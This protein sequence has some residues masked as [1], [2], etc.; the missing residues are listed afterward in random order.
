MNCAECQTDPLTPGHYCPCC[1]RKLSLQEQRAAEAN[2]PACA[3][4]LASAIAAEPSHDVTSAAPQNTEVAVQKAEA[5]DMTTEVILPR[6]VVKVD[7]AKIAKAKA[8][9][10][11]TAKAHL[12]KA[13]NPAPVVRR[14][15]VPPPPPPPQR[16][17]RTPML[18][19]AAAVIVGA[20]GAAEG[21]RRLG[22]EWPGHEAREAAPVE[23]TA[24][25]ESVAPV[26]R[27]AT[28]RQAASAPANHT[29]SI[30][31]SRAAA[32]PKVSAP[33]ARRAPVR[34]GN[35]TPQQVAP[36]VART[37]A[38]ETP[39]P[40]PK[41]IAPKAAES[42]RPS[43]PLTGRFF[44]SNDVDEPPHIARRVAPRLPANLPAGA[45]KKI[46]VARVLVSRTG[47]PYH[48]SLLRGS[49]LGRASDEAVIAAVTQWTFSPARKR[50]EAVNCWYN[51]GVPLARAN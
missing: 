40:A 32:K 48:V 34:Q 3:A 9:A 15:I 43:A 29:T 51:I 42:A 24:P 27:R 7:A 16:A 11:E 39:A 23:A 17:S 1:G 5:V 49:T 38:P 33:A 2:S 47:Q 46:V 19:M 45:D 37:P 28:T 41:A 20:I 14:P 21:A 12:A 50:G 26:A 25:V 8:A 31:P 36:I 30:A 4:V 10:D 22:F 13:A 44:E 18:V 35:P 6:P